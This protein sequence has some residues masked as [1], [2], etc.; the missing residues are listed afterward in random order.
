MVKV[1][2]LLYRVDGFNEQNTLSAIPGPLYQDAGDQFIKE[3][4]GPLIF[5]P[6]EKLV[7][8]ILENI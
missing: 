4:L 2:T 3:L 7:K 6:G 5:D 8:T 1:S